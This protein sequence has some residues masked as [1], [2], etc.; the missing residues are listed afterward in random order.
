MRLIRLICPLLFLVLY[1]LPLQAQGVD[2]PRGC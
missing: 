2:A 1:A